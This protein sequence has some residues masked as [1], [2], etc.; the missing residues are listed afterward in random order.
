MGRVQRLGRELRVIHRSELIQ[1]RRA[2]RTPNRCLRGQG[3]NVGDDEERENGDQ[4]TTHDDI[5]ER[6]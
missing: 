6:R 2:Q 1:I 5:D 4:V 3:R